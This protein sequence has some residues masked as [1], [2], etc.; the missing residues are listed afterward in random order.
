MILFLALL[1]APGIVLTSPFWWFFLNLRWLPHTH[2][3]VR[4]QRPE[5]AVY[6]S[7]ELSLW[8]VLSSPGLG[9]V[10]PICFGPPG[11][12]LHLLDFRRLLAS[13]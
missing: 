8:K 12:H 10:S 5:G 9:K 7:L 4:C 1:R 2:G 3:L 6:S 13:A 11:S